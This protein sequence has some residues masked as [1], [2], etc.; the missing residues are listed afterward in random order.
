[1]ATALDGSVEGGSQ[2]TK[3]HVRLVAQLAT[4]RDASARQPHTGGRGLSEGFTRSAPSRRRAVKVTRRLLALIS[5]IILGL[6]VAGVSYV[7]FFPPDAISGDLALVHSDRPGLRVLFIG[8]SF[9]AR[10]SMI[11]MVRK[12]AENDPGAQPIFTVAYAPGGS[13]LAVAARDRRLTQLLQSARWDDVVLQEQSRLPALPGLRE[14]YMFPAAAF[15][16][17]MAKRIGARTVLFETWGYKQGDPGAYAGDAYQAMQAR[18]RQGYAELSS[19]LGALLAPVGDAWSTSVS[20]RP[21]FDLW[22]SDSHHPSQA[23]SYLTAC[24]FFAVLSH[25]DPTMSRFM[26]GLDPFEARWLEAVAEYSVSQTHS[27]SS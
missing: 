12:L 14:R 16:D 17:N 6:V 5:T 13:T 20:S 19:D 2:P 9:T 21:A 1:M 27:S 7:K 10:H 24:V 15:L 25:R 23:G 18:V 3:P 11:T 26:G 8:N 4:G 22:E